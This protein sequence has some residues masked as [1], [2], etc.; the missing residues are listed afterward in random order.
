MPLGNIYHPERAG[1]CLECGKS[2]LGIPVTIRGHI[3]S[4]VGKNYCSRTCFMRAMTREQA[5]KQRERRAKL[6]RLY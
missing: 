3:Q 6:S 4:Q 2:L 1:K 5:R